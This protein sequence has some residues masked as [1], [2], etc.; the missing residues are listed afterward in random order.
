MCDFVFD[1]DLW[2]R[3]TDRLAEP[4]KCPYPPVVGSQFCA[5][6]INPAILVR[7][8]GSPS[9]LNWLYKETIRPVGQLQIF[10]CTVPYLDFQEIK[11]VI[12]L[13]KP[14]N[15]GY[16]TFLNPIDLSG[17]T[18]N[19]NLSIADCRLSSINLNGSKIT[20]RL[21]LW[22]SNVGEFTCNSA[23]ILDDSHFANSVF[24]DTFFNNTKF[25]GSVSFCEEQP[26]E[27]SIEEVSENL[28]TDSAEFLRTPNFLGTKFDNL[29]IFSGVQFHDAAV[30]SDAEFQ[31]GTSFKKAQAEVGMHFG[32]TRFQGKA[33]FVEAELGY[34]GFT[35]AHFNDI[36]RFED[37]QFGGLFA[38]YLVD[39]ISKHAAAEGIEYG[40]NYI[41]SC[42]RAM[43]NP[44]MSFLASEM[45]H[46]SAAFTGSRPDEYFYFE[47]ISATSGINLHHVNFDYLAASAEI[48]R[49]RLD[50]VE[51][52]QATI[53]RGDLG[54]VDSDSSIYRL[55]KATI[56]DVHINHPE[57]IGAFDN[58]FIGDTKFTEFD[59]S[60]YRDSLINCDWMIDGLRNNGN[61]IPYPK[62][63][64]TYAKAKA[65]A[66]RQGDTYAESNF[67]ILERR[68]RRNRYISDLKNS[69]TLSE[70]AVSG[71]NAASNY[72]YDLSCEYGESPGRVFTISLGSI[73]IFALIY[74]L[75]HQG[76]PTGNITQ[77]TVDFEAATDYLIFSLQAFTSFFLPGSLEPDNRG[78][79]LVSS[80]QSF[81]GAFAIALFVATLVRTVQR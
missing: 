7:A 11:D 48:N 57:E 72:L 31:M 56:G 26:P 55:E 35:S 70:R 19:N 21:H 54:V 62:R 6:H 18:L 74:W 29:A 36:V 75:L 45:G 49:K 63:E 73:F 8:L 61:R 23:E 1:P 17:I 58:L 67:F 65:G 40:S 44:F 14:I 3:D 38:P 10:C 78:V 30:F 42:S 51:L 41:E 53:A 32:S 66:A 60:N 28:G 68:C 4:Q 25:R 59:F 16:S 80:V 2:Y 81:F 20:G 46:L 13:S 76:I 9:Q 34:A 15:I 5:F 43:Q 52:T 77:Y 27:A 71:Y 50:A 37:C 69:T 33:D 79:H 12:D 47:N 64:T 24:G 22:D 39:S